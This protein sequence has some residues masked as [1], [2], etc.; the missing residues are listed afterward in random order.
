M[1]FNLIT[2]KLN[3][4]PPPQSAVARP[5]LYEQLGQGSKLIL[6]SA[7]AGAG[8]S[9]LLGS[10]LRHHRAAAWLSLDAGDNDLEY[11]LLYV[12]AALQQLEPDFG[13]ELSDLLQTQLAVQPEAIVIRLLNE[14]ARFKQQF[15]LVL[16]DYHVITNPK[17]H[18]AIEFLLDHLPAHLTL[19][20]ATRVD[21]PLALSRLRVRGQ[22][23][24]IRADDLRF[25]PSEIAELLNDNLHLGLSEAALSS[26]EERTEGWVA[27]L[28]LAA[29]SL[30]GRKDKEDFVAAFAGSHR[31]LVDYLMDEV[32]AKQT[33]EVRQF[34][35]RTSVLGRFTLSL[36]QAVTEERVNPD[37]LHHLET[38]NLFLIPL[39][40]ER[41]WYRYHHLFAEF[42]R[43]RLRESEAKEIPELHQRASSW[44][45]GQGLIDEAIG[46]A[47]LA[48]NFAL[49]GR[50]VETIAFNLGV[51]WNNAQ[52]IKYVERLP[53]ELLPAHPRLC[54][55][56][57]WALV[58]TGQVDTL[59]MVLNVLESNPEHVQQPPIIVACVMTLRA[60]QRVWQLDFS[61]AVGLCQQAL[62]VLGSAE[63]PNDEERWLRVA[64]TNLIAYSYLHGDLNV[65]NTFYPSARANSQKLGNFVGTINSFARHG[66][67]KHQLG[68][69]HGALEVF[70]LGLGT[71]EGWRREKQE[72][73]VVNVGELPLNLA[74]LCYEWNRLDEVETY[75]EQARTLNELSQFPPVLARELETSFHLYQARGETE[76]AH[77]LLRKLERMVA[78]VHPNN[79]FYQ[80]LF[81]VTAMN[82]RLWL[83][84][85]GT[86][87]EHLLGEVSG[88]VEGRNLK[89][90]D[91]FSYP[92]EASYGVLAHC[93]LA[94]GKAAA[95]LPLL[96]RLVQ[97]ARTQGRMDDL[98]HYALWQ[99]LTQQ[100]LGREAKALEILQ[101][102]LAFAEPQG[103]CR[104]FVDEGAPMKTLLELA[105][106]QTPS[107]YLSKLLAAFPNSESKPPVGL[108]H[109]SSV[110]T[111]IT[112][113]ITT[114]RDKDWPL[115]EREL[116]VLRLLSGGQSNKGIAK[117]LQLSPNTVKWYVQGLYDKLAVNNRLQAVNR[118]K[119]LGLF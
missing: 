5:Q 76:A 59:A 69:L 65:A 79:L 15:M 45:E 24:E 67:V 98:L 20:I 108:T 41:K 33:Q 7:P 60:Y 89:P 80:E 62:A 87:H 4:P 83:A 31:Y 97:G 102:V 113:D 90:S 26:L 22:L 13:R 6:V 100:S 104:S 14:L 12:V 88:W 40:D 32:L 10:W 16:D 75:L 118:A 86:Q 107:T 27:G 8:K 37:L 51:S 103:Y 49:A 19:V 1:S 21:P 46:H 55:Y 105:F 61:G 115:S 92:Y 112:R 25:S 17:I 109:S 58:N 43:H 50:L 73:S 11:F 68:Q 114:A 101:E 57:T 74:R 95:A 111:T 72:R 23:L 110:P 77:A 64:A 93:L 35:Q 47:L 53:L 119:E 38:A 29:L 28:Q 56:Y 84:V 70:K 85:P 106:E 66:R 78:E 52:L 117:E 82:L 30:T 96:E 94:Q 18:D 44:L 54:I 3:A 63:L 42:L 81:S 39:D 34:L 48:K 9:T 36:C 116:T 71:L 91:A 2:T 99:A